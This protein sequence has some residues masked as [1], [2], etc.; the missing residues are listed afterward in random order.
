M[1]TNNFCIELFLRV[2][3]GVTRG[4]VLSK[5]DGTTGYLL[6]V[7]D[8]G[9]LMLVLET[10]S[11]WDVQVVGGQIN[12]GK[13]HHVLAEIDRDNSEAR[14][15]MDGAL[16][17]KLSL[18]ELGKMSLSNDGDFLLGKGPEGDYF[19]GAL[20]FLRISRGSLAD[21][22]TSIEELR[23]WQFQGPASRD[24]TGR[25]RSETTDAGA[26]EASRE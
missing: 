9:D 7:D 13:W 3:K 2:K 14:M 17:G 10:D 15:Y 1:D 5:S 21:A 20:D 19:A 22:R 25:E 18:K 24:F 16:G 4:T 12:D 26:L 11:K 6:R 23:A 8:H